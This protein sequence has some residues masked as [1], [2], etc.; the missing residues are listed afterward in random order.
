M[1][2]IITWVLSLL[3][4]VFAATAYAALPESSG[5][6]IDAGAGVGVTDEKMQANFDKFSEWFGASFGLGYQLNMFMGLEGGVIRYPD[7]DLSG[8]KSSNRNWGVDILGKAIMPFDNGFSLFAKGGWARLYQNLSGAGNDNG[9]HEGDTLMLGAGASFFV[10]QSLGF[11]LQGN[12]TAKVKTIPE[13]FL[14]T[15]GIVYIF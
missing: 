14:A 7:F 4:I 11:T 6:Y 1:K 13:Q 10:D 9:R 5:V 15:F 8:N 3:F 2:R 12:M